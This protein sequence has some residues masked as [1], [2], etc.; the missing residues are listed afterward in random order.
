M[1]LAKKGLNQIEASIGKDDKYSHLTEEEI[2][3]VD[4]TIQEKWIWL[5]EKR[6][7]LASL[8]RTQQ[9]PVMVAQ[10]RS[11]K[12]VSIRKKYCIRL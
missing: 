12:Y 7:L 2:K 3:T 8:P 1:Q 10:I 4:K 11:E 5:E 6:M 9:P